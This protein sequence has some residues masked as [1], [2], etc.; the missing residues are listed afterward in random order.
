[1]NIPFPTRR[2]SGPCPTSVNDCHTMTAGSSASFAAHAGKLA[3]RSSRRAVS[4]TKALTSRSDRWHSHAQSSGSWA[5]ARGGG[6]ERGRGAGTQVG[7]WQGRVGRGD[8][9]GSAGGAGVRCARP[10]GDARFVALKG[11]RAGQA[12]RDTCA[13][14]SAHTCAR[15]CAGMQRSRG[16]PP[17]GLHTRLRPQEQ[18]HLEAR[19]Q[20]PTEPD[21]QHD[22]DGEHVAGGVQRDLVVRPAAPPA[23]ASGAAGSVGMGV[24]GRV[25]CAGLARGRR[26]CLRL[27]RR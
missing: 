23:A 1:M 6:G 18:P 20:V 11:E 19:Q 14:V 16:R 3:V 25:A 17:L 13:H 12:S 10:R 9:L 24:C 22:A 7:R 5:P 26:T 8:H 2:M 4:V 15:R 21:Q 27:R